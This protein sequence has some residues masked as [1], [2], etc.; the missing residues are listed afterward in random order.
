MIK[1]KQLLEKIS[2]RDDFAWG[3]NAPDYDNR[4]FEQI[5]SPNS[6][7][8]AYITHF[9]EG[10]TFS[11]DIND[12]WGRWMINFRVVNETILVK[13]KRANP[14]RV[15]STVSTIIYDFLSKYKIDELIVM[16]ASISHHK[17]YRRL[18]KNPVFLNKLD[19]IGYEISP[20]YA[21]IVSV[22]IKRKR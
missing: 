11:V 20:D 18:A 19:D 8:K 4:K 7:A 6:D 15:I 2:I 5:K 1:Y 17:I 12:D 22:V 16:G 13:S 10:D 21:E 9:K 3:S 14:Q